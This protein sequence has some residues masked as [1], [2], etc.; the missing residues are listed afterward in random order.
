M[1]KRYLLSVM[2][3]SMEE[4]VIP[5]TNSLETEALVKPED[6]IMVGISPMRGGLLEPK[7]CIRRARAQSVH[8]EVES[9]CSKYFTGRYFSSDSLCLSGKYFWMSFKIPH[10]Y[11]T[12]KDVNAYVSNIS[13]LALNITRCHIS[14][15][16]GLMEHPYSSAARVGAITGVLRRRRPTKTFLVSTGFP[17]IL[18]CYE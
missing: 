9:F 10:V 15:F 4:A 16:N 11:L 12:S 1:K 13:C 18:R 3:T 2:L 5:K 8:G 7:N 17:Q 14:F 6:N